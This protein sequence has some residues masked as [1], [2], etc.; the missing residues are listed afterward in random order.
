M[1]E[2]SLYVEKSLHRALTSH[3][4]AFVEQF[5]IITK[6]VLAQHIEN[7]SHVI[8]QSIYMPLAFQ[9]RVRAL[10]S[11]ASAITPAPT[12]FVGAIGLK[13]VFDNYHVALVVGD[14]DRP[15]TE[16][17]A[18]SFLTMQSLAEGVYSNKLWNNPDLMNNL[19]YNTPSDSLPVFS[20][21]YTLSEK[22][23]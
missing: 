9:V 17:N 3:G 8:D 6:Q 7:V 14:D 22:S 18:Q 16:A 2:V 13:K 1:I 20:L 23:V 15:F 19:V 10:G 21:T 11:L 5:L 4:D 12:W